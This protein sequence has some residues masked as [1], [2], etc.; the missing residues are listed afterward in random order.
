M[1]KPSSLAEALNR[2]TELVEAAGV[3]KD[4]ALS[5]A[6]QLAAAVA[7]SATGAYTDWA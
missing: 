6:T 1:T 4:K 2:L 7:D 3:D 5:A